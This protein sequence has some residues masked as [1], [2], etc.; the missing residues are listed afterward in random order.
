[1]VVLL[2]VVHNLRG[3]H[4]H[5]VVE[6]AEEEEVRKLVCQVKLGQLL[7]LEVVHPLQDVVVVLVASRALLVARGQVSADEPQGHAPKEE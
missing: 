6:V 4:V 3:T 1:M 2:G 7:L 5:P